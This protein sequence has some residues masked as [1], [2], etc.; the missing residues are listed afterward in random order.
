MLPTSEADQMQVLYSTN[1]RMQVVKA[2]LSNWELR[3]A[4]PLKNKN[5][6]PRAFEA[7]EFMYF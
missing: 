2:L 5:D 4:K 3:L 7:H 1:G 6:R